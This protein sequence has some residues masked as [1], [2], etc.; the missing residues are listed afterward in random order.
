[1]LPGSLL[2]GAIVALFSAGVSATPQFG[3]SGSQEQNQGED[4]SG[5]N[6]FE[7]SPSTSTYAATTIAYT[8]TA[9]AATS[10]STDTST[11]CNNSPDLC[12]RAYN[13]ITHMGAHDSSFLRDDSTDDSVAGNQFY[14]ATYA[15][16]AGLR[17][18][19]AQVHVENGTLELCHTTC[20][21]LD[22]GPLADWLALIRVWMDDNPNE[23]VSLVLVNSD[24]ADVADIAAAF[25]TAGL[26]SYGYT[27]ATTEATGD[28]PTLRTMIEANTRLVSFIASIT[29]DS[30]YPYLLPEFAYVFE[31]AFEV[32]SLSGFNC[33]LDRPSSLTDDGYATAISSNYMPML[34]HFAYKT[35]IS[36][37]MI[38]DVDDI[39]TTNS[40]DTSTTGALGTHADGC[41]SEWGVKPVLVLVDFF[42][43]GDVMA[44]ADSLNGI[45]NAVGR[46]TDFEDGGSTSGATGKF[47][48]GTGVALVTFLAAALFMF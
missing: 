8:A 45:S 39:E 18:L 4:G 17:L 14:N 25:E 19:Q 26:D 32:L 44:V 28:W 37:V 34:N 36:S 29:Y 31:T 13:N 10:S 40:D 42:D 6:T 47:D 3:G 2:T 43:Q 15:L 16:E 11:A 12:D 24:D 46:S 9:L 33:T 21:L 48:V 35:L 23:V 27:P 1:M 30:T 41:T 7:S 5:G 20:S 22:A 38:P